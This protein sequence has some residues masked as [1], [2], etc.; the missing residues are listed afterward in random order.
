MVKWVESVDCDSSLPIIVTT[1][2][3]ISLIFQILISSTNRE[4]LGNRTTTCLASWP[5]FIQLIITTLEL[6]LFH[7][8]PG[9][10]TLT[11]PSDKNGHNL[12][13]FLY[14]ICFSHLL[15]H[16]QI[17]H[18][19][20]LFPLLLHCLLLSLH[21]THT[22]RIVYILWNLL[23][24]WHFSTPLSQPLQSQQITI[25]L[26]NILLYAH[27]QLLSQQ[28]LLSRITTNNILP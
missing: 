3:L 14:Q 7:Y 9:M 16:I 13:N 5:L 2:L 22:V 23:S 27:R 26:K 21:I 24:L 15:I 28:H 25:M 4:F 12:L 17:L 20:N 18:L 11:N 19:L 6:Q 1:T 10:T 8:F